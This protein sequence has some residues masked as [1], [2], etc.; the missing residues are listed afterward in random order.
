MRDVAALA[1]RQPEDGVPRR[2]R[3]ARGLARRPRAGHRRRATGSTTGPTWP[4]ATCAA[5]APAPGSIGALVQDLSNSFSASLLRA[6]EDS[7]RRHGT[8]VLAASLDEERRPRGGARPRPGHPPGRR[9]GHHARERAAGLPRQ[10][11]CARARRPSSSTARRAASTPT[12]SPSTTT[13]GPA[14][15]ASTCWPRATAGS[16]RSSTSRASPPPRGGSPG[17]PTPTPSAACAPTRALVVTGLR[18]TDEATEVMHALLALDDPPTA[19]FTGA[20]H[21]LHRGGSRAGRAR[22]AARGGPRR[23]RRLP[24]GRPARPAADRHPAGRRADRQDRRRPALRP[25][26]RQHLARRGTSCT[27]RPSSCAAPARSHRRPPG[28]AWRPT[29]GATRV[30]EVRPL[31][32]VSVSCGPMVRR[33]AVDAGTRRRRAKVMNGLK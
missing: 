26:R 17:S 33:S 25:D 2:Q 32:G 4:R 7:A 5:P 15:R 18:S 3:R 21:P 22:A 16:P 29:L 6:L 27:S 20:E 19:V 12:R 30:I 24:A 31:V 1:G 11:S 14:G 9:A 28:R 13:A 8:A 10:P 23:V